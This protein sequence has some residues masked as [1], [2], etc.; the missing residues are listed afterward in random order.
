MDNPVK[1]F[2]LLRFLSIAITISIC[3]CN[4]IL[5]SAPCKEYERQ[6]LLVFK[7]DLKGPSNRLLSW[8]GGER[9]C[10]NWT[11]VV[12]DK[13]PAMSASSTSEIIIQMRNFRA[14]VCPGFG[15]TI[16]PQLG[17]IL[18][19]RALGLFDNDLVVENLE[20]ISGLSLLQHL[21]I[22]AIDLSKVSHWLQGKNTL[23]LSCYLETL[24]LS[25]NNFH[26]EIS[27]YIGNLT[28]LVN[29]DI[30]DNQLDGKVPNSLGNLCKLMVL[31]LSKNNFSGGVSEIFES[32]S[33][34]SSGRMVYLAL[35]DNNLSGHLSYQ[36]DLSNSSFSGTLFHFLCDK[37]DGPKQLQILR[38]HNNSLIGEIPDCLDNLQNLELLNLENNNLIGNIPASFVGSIPTR[39][40]K[41]LSHLGVLSLRS[42]MLR[43][44]IPHELC[45]LRKLQILDLTDN[46]LF[47]AIPTC[48]NNFTAMTNFSNSGG[49]ILFYTCSLGDYGFFED[50]DIENAILVSKGRETKYTN[51]LALVT[52]LDLSDNVIS[53]E[54][55]EE[56]TSLICLQSLNLSNNRLVGKSLQG[57]I[58]AS[59]SKLTFLS[60]LNLSD[61][62]LSGKIPV[63]AQL[64]SFDPSSFLG[65]KLC[66]PPLEE[67]STNHVEG[68]SSS[69]DRKREHLFVYSKMIGST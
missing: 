65:N 47:G 27:S 25:E 34:C 59:V 52:S 40:G 18:S 19:L 50:Y 20:W 6:A 46:N 15:G 35:S 11:G 44:N 63:S 61:N 24:V 21:N 67:C 68:P 48:F 53:G 54:I 64:Q 49:P 26:G 10:C 57:L 4:G 12:C 5:I 62:N 1:V 32:F 2:S 14:R 37:T 30:F 43:G 55:P 8:V 58:S 56:L 22:A 38:L 29:L 60:Y 9:D 66:G 42:N 13:K 39:I 16:P 45:S 28:A 41:S 7:Q 23:P 17:N 31:D 51:K 33:R 36:L 3:L 69:G